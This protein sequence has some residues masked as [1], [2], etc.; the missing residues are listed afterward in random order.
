MAKLYTIT[1][2]DVLWINLRITNKVQQYRYALL[3]E[4]TNYQYTLGPNDDPIAAAARLLKGFSRLKPLACGNSATGFAA[5]VTYLLGN[6]FEL[7]LSDE[8]ATDWVM[9]IESGAHD[10]T[11]AFRE[12]A[13][14]TDGHH[15]TRADVQGKIAK[16]AMSRYSATLAKLYEMENAAFA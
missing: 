7:K 8:E 13:V 16:E 2:Q 12:M 6:G 3:E 14:H 5:A 15:E 4:A 10:A 1:V 11:V 9:K